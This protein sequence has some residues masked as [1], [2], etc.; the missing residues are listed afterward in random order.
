MHKAVTVK[1]AKGINIYTWLRPLENINKC[2]LSCYTLTCSIPVS[3]FPQYSFYRMI[4]Y[5][6]L[7]LPPVLNIILPLWFTRDKTVKYWGENLKNIVNN[8]YFRPQH[9]WRRSRDLYKNGNEI[10]GEHNTVREF[11]A[12]VYR[13]ICYLEKCKEYIQEKSSK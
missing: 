1:S 13:K 2:N 4:K 5:V 6:I 12:F 3:R 7:F 9:P 10:F 11:F 8:E